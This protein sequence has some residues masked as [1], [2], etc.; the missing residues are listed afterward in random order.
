MIGGK[1]PTYPG[2][3]GPPASKYNY[4]TAV[5]EEPSSSERT[6]LLSRSSYHNIDL[7][8]RH[9]LL[10]SPSSILFIIFLVVLL[11]SFGDQLQEAPFTRILE[12]VICYQ[13]YE[14]VDP[15]KINLDRSRVGPGAIGGV[16]EMYCKVDKVQDD[17]AM[18][19]GIQ[20]FLDGFPALAL[21]I[22]FGWAADRYGR[23]PFLMLGVVQFAART[24][25]LQLVAWFW[26]SLDVRATWFQSAF[27]LLGGGTTTASALFFVTVS[28][29]TT[30]SDRAGAFLR[31]GA[32]NLSANLFMPPVAAWLMT[33][34][35]WIPALMGTGFMCVAAVLYLFVPETLDYFARAN[36]PTS[37]DDP[38]MT[39]PDLSPLHPSTPNTLAT[40]IKAVLTSV[41][42]ALAFLHRDWRVP[43]LIL[44]FTVHV[45]IASSG[46]LLIQYVSKR[47]VLTFSK[48]TLLTTV[49]TGVQVALL[50]II[51]PKISELVMTRFGLGIQKKDLYLAR[52]SQCLVAIGWL[53]VAAAPNVVLVGIALAVSSLGYGAMLL[54]R[55]FIT[56]LVPTHE[57]ARTYSVIGIVDTLGTMFGS[58]LLAGLFKRGMGLGG[59]FVGL[60]YYL[61][62]G[63]SVLFAL[64][65]FAVRLRKGEG[66]EQSMLDDDDEQR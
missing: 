61:I 31:L 40:R 29:V 56:S 37:I 62:G 51:L 25:W 53:G 7:N 32:A 24:V 28:D 8:P 12:S 35:P 17:L 23:W 19:S 14:D 11:T 5:T 45:L 13:Y 49:K 58:P 57:V 46:R 47:Y 41:K 64:L 26:E 65:M 15:S 60:P 2:D 38:H 16:D 39:T 10:K 42:S 3:E 54:L 33:I 36:P 9:R 20:G 48:A 50:F 55:S 43:A 1:G 59:P 4:T 27:S 22:P 52:L 44:P 66:E 63:L 6:P 18:L 34:N 30:E 21:A